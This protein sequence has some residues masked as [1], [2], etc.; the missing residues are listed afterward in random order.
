MILR[1][2]NL[3]CLRIIHLHDFFYNILPLTLNMISSEYLIHFFFV[4][5]TIDL[6]VNRGA[7]IS[8]FFF[9]QYRMAIN[10]QLTMFWRTILSIFTR[11][12]FVA[13]WKS[14]MWK[15]LLPVYPYLTIELSMEVKVLNLLPLFSINGL[16]YEEIENRE[17]QRNLIL[18]HE[19]T[20]SVG[21]WK[22]WVKKS[23]RFATVSSV[24]PTSKFYSS[25]SYRLYF[26]L[27]Y[28]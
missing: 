17:F 13:C 7:F 3:Q 15:I 2:K 1:K 16:N 11:N 20:T 22:S 24:R 21:N 5:A 8:I 27:L 9:K 10:T 26:S 19:E 25:I 18:S 4:L 6:F 14:F 12:W 23:T 28:D